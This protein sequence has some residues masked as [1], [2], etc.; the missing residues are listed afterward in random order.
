MLLMMNMSLM[1]SAKDGAKYVPTELSADVCYLVGYEHYWN[2]ESI[3]PIMNQ[4]T[5]VMRGEDKALI[6][7]IIRN[8]KPINDLT[9]HSA[10]TERYIA[11]ENKDF[12]SSF[13]SIR[14]D[15]KAISFKIKS[16]PYDLTYTFVIPKKYRQQTLDMI[17]RYKSQLPLCQTVKTD[18]YTPLAMYCLQQGQCITG[19][20]VCP[21]LFFF[22]KAPCF[23][24]FLAKAAYTDHPVRITYKC[25][26][27][28]N[29]MSV[30]RTLAMV[31]STFDDVLPQNAPL[32]NMDGKQIGNRYNDSLFHSKILKVFPE[33][34]NM[35]LSARMDS[36]DATFMR[37]LRHH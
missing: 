20:A 25:I 19:L 22:Y 35:T 12:K 36:L 21:V 13:R 9:W 1:A 6:N 11:I 31:D 15:K 34:N 32:K 28:K 2:S 23:V 14:I 24:Q 18:S 37:H 30:S 5:V 17:N 7:E 4:P 27:S 3:E 8:A 29:D 16:R 33:W 26:F 10:V